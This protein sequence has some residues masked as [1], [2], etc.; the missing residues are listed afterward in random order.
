MENNCIPSSNNNI[1]F[2]ETSN[3]NYLPSKGI[4]S[5]TDIDK[6]GNQISKYF[7]YFHYFHFQVMPT[8]KQSTI[9]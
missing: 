5:G 4:K 8:L 7:N 1:Y 3:D 6:Y 2:S 9:T